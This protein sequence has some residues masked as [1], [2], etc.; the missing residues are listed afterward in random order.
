MALLALTRLSQAFVPPLYLSSG[1]VSKRNAG[2]DQIEQGADNRSGQRDKYPTLRMF[3]QA[4]CVDRFAARF[5]FTGVTVG[6]A[7]SFANLASRSLCVLASRLA[8]SLSMIVR[9]ARVVASLFSSCFE[10]RCPN[11]A[12][13]CGTCFI[14]T[15]LSEKEKRPGV[16]DLLLIA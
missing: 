8:A 16:P 1:S 6:S 15:T 4:S 11:G 10:F 2:K 3:H 13:I 9:T 12:P 7:A 5:G 14:K